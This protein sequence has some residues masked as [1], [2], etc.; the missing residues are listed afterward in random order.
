MHPSREAH[1]L[2]AWIFPMMLVR[3]QMATDI[4][5]TP[6]ISMKRA[7]VPSRL[8]A[9]ASPPARAAEA[10]RPRT[11]ATALREMSFFIRSPVGGGRRCPAG[12]VSG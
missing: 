3:I 12:R 4:A 5:T 7:L 6:P 9:G 8:V 2:E 1:F 11:A 10:V